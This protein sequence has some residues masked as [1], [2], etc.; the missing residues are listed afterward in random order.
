MPRK[1]Q[2]RYF[3]DFD[4]F[5]IEQ[6]KEFYRSL[7]RDLR[8]DYLQPGAVDKDIFA[9]AR[10]IRAGNRVAATHTVI[11]QD[12][13]DKPIATAKPDTRP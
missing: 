9:R 2:F 11:Y 1:A 6:P 8:V 5:E 10:V 4:L 12:N 13:I 7:H 3:Q